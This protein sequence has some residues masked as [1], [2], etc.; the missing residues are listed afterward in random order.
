MNTKVS[1][2]VPAY[3]AAAYLR[4]CIESALAQ[5]F[6]DFELVLVDNA[7]TD[8]TVAIAHEY[9]R[10]DRR[11]G[12]YQNA[13]NIG[14]LGNF[15]RCLDLAQGEW[16]KFLCTD[17]WLQPTCLERLLAEARPGVLVMTCTEDYAFDEV[18]DQA[19]KQRHLNYRN[20]HCLR[21]SRRFPGRAF[22][23]A[24]EFSELVAE[25]PPNHS[26]TLNSA[27][28]HRS[29]IDQNGRFNSDLLNLNDWELFA[30]IG[31]HT[32]VI[33]VAEVLATF[34]VRESSVGNDTTSRRPFMMEVISP[35]LI[36]YEAVHAPVYSPVRAAAKRLNIDLARQLFNCASD[37]RQSA[38]TYAQAY[39]DRFALADWDETVRRYPRLLA[40]RPNYYFARNWQRGK[41]MLRRAT[42]SLASRFVPAR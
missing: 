8:D 25:D 29:A 6:G 36:R 31:I 37:A 35:L 10:I 5:T 11:I 17:D 19:E 4:Q 14:F 30:R 39:G 16:L 41:S 12:V 26:M 32:G 34:R 15:N 22:V 2:C 20:D 21:L 1:V 24:Q 7:S 23:S 42:A 33:N 28:V 27:M 18:I 38:L 3:N 40:G 9:A 13:Q